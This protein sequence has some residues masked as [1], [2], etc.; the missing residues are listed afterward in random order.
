[1]GTTQIPYATK[2]WNVTVGCTHA[3]MKGCDH[4]WARDLHEMRNSAYR[5]GK[6]VPKQYAKS[7]GEI[8]LR[9]DRLDEPLRWRNPQRVFVCSMSDLF[10]PLVPFDFIHEVYRRIC[11]CP[12]HTFLIFTKR[13][14]ILS[15]FTQAQGNISWPE[16]ANIIVSCSTQKELDENVP[17]LLDIPAAVRGISLEP[18][19]EEI[20]LK[21]IDTDKTWPFKSETSK[22]EP[23]IG[24]TYSRRASNPNG[25]RFMDTNGPRLDWVIVGAESGSKRR[26]CKIEWIRKVAQDCQ[27]ANVPI[28]VKQLDIGG[29]VITDPNKFP[30]DL[31]NLRQIP[32]E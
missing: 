22:L 25:G 31:R 17:I 21:Y 3:G 1:M 7:F 15:E 26:P 6:H 5:V 27:N 12:K 4:C 13:I 10:H 30:A 11:S 18:L 8:V 20:D 24:G 32:N 23:L 19:I 9:P 29:K 14:K 28:Y 2:S 16:N